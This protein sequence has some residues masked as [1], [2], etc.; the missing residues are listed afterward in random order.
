MF[1]DADEKYKKKLIEYKVTRIPHA[2]SEV[3]F[4]VLVILI[5]IWKLCRSQLLQVQT[6]KS[7]TMP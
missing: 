4:L 5:T 2:V 6:C 1:R 3:L 7:I